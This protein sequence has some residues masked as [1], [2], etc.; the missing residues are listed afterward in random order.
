MSIADNLELT[1]L[2]LVILK[3]ITMKKIFQN[4]SYLLLASATIFM[5]SCSDDDSAEK[6]TTDPVSNKVINTYS[7]SATYGDLVTFSINNTDLTYSLYNETT[8]QTESGSYSVMDSEFSGVY[9][10]TAGS[11]NFYG[12]ELG[13]KIVVGNFPSGNSNNDLSFGVS[14]EIDNST[15]LGGFQ[16]NYFYVKLGAYLQND[17]MEWGQFSLTSDSLHGYD[18]TD[19]TNGP[20]DTTIMFPLSYAN[21]KFDG[22]WKLSGTKSDRLDINIEGNLATGYAFAEGNTSVFLIDLGTGEGSVIAYKVDPNSTLSNI[23]DTY[24]YIEFYQDGEKG[25][26]NYTLSPNGSVSYSY[27]NG[28]TSDLETNVNLLSNFQSVNPQLPN[29]F[30]AYNVNSEGNN[31]YFVVAGDAIMHY[32]FDS[33]FNFLGYGAGASL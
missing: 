6:N 26:G 21:S 23:A 16:G 11:T 24:K 25:A 13:D 22:S 10:I 15:Q 5:V 12:V 19:G 1:H 32:H 4:A 7:G 17:P 2:V 14:S 33:N 27:T 29:V 9:E 20:E 3:Q 31:L 30:Y 8:S 28:D 18:M